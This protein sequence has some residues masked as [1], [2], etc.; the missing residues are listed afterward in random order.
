LVL[1]SWRTK[2]K[3]T[4]PCQGATC[5]SVLSVKTDV[6]NPQRWEFQSGDLVEISDGV[7]RML[8]AGGNFL[9]LP[10]VLL[11]VGAFLSLPLGILDLIVGFVNLTIKPEACFRALRRS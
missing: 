7:G 4:P 6:G 1:H 11:G 2:F 9:L 3:E 10:A 5:C 8:L